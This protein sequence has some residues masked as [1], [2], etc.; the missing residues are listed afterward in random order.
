L[1]RR[2]VVL[3]SVTNSACIEQVRRIEELLETA[4]Q[5]KLFG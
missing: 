5:M 4:H 1:R 2:L 3:F